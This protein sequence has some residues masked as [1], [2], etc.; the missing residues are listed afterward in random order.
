MT[1]TQVFLG[2]GSNR[3]RRQHMQ[4]GIRA[5]HDRFASGQQPMRVAR[6][7]ESAAVGFDGHDFYNTVVGFHTDLPL[8]ALSEVCKQIEQA[9]GH[10]SSLPKYSPRTLDI[11]LLLYG[12]LVCAKPIQ[13]PRPEVLFNAFVLWPLAELAPSYKHPE[14]QQNFAELWQNFHSEQVLKPIEFRYPALPY[15]ITPESDK[16]AAF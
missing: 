8:T 3:Q 7:F 1:L 9:N 5:L 13:L 15:L 11:D 2:L 14:I 12:D 4:A 10:P 6:M 16:E